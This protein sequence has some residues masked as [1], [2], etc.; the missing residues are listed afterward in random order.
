MENVIFIPSKQNTKFTSQNLPHTQRKRQ[1]ETECDTA[2]TQ[3]ITN[4][5]KHFTIIARTKKTKPA[6][7]MK[8]KNITWT[9]LWTV[10]MIYIITFYFWHTKIHTYTHIMKK[11]KKYGFVI[12]FLATNSLF[13]QP[14][15]RGAKT[16]CVCIHDETTT[17]TPLQHW[18]LTYDDD[19]FVH[20]NYFVI[21]LMMDTPMN[22]VITHHAWLSIIFFRFLSEN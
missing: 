10:T 22:N 5:I 13:D 4:A 6:K 12:A 14:Q 21:C 1:Y 18:F 7:N 2:R 19:D 8:K 20:I 17:K 3:N 15:I 9:Y 11:I 16:V